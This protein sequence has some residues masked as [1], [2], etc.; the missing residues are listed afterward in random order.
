MKKI[1]SFLSLLLILNSSNFAQ[2]DTNFTAIGEVLTGNNKKVKI[3]FYDWKILPQK[4]QTGEL[5]KHFEKIVFDANVT[6]WLDVAMVEV[7]AVNGKTVELDI[8]EEK[9]EIVVNG[10]KTNHFLKGKTMKFEWSQK[11]QIEEYI[12]HYENGKIKVKGNIICKQ[13]QGKWEYF[14]EKSNLIEVINYKNDLKN[15][16]NEK[17]WLNGNLKAKQNFVNDTVDGIVEFYWSNG[18]K[19]S[20]FTFVMGQKEGEY[21]DW[22]QKGNLKTKRTYKNDE[23]D[24]KI[25]V[26]SPETGEKVEEIPYKN[27]IKQGQYVKYSYLNVI[28]EIG[29]YKNAKKHGK[30]KYFYENG[31]ELKVENYSYDILHGEYK[32]FYLEA[33][34]KIKAKYNY[35]KLQGNW[36]SF[37]ENR[38]IKEKGKYQNGSK[39][40]EWLEYYEDGSP[41]SQGFY[42][43]DKKTGKWF[44]WDEDG[45]KKKEKFD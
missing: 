42:D 8:L 43:S 41:K 4:G 34:P 1:V 36:V 37:Y 10:E 40:G 23:I 29:N 39:E 14:D 19:A 2:C 22:D 7:K 30:W 13:K 26:F 28:S 5:H 24:K 3:S 12:E 35:G 16:L 15:G 45:K 21:K 9:S 18:N 31:D 33:K 11:P 20:M 17:Y 27:G 25:T 44:F 38:Q 32:E 6:G